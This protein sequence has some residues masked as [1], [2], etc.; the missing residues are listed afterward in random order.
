MRAAEAALRAG[1]PEKMAYSTRET[2]LY[3]GI[4]YREVIAAINS[5]ELRALIPSGKARGWYVRPEA[6]DEWMGGR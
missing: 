4:R 6:V 3:T 5:G 1:L 2:A